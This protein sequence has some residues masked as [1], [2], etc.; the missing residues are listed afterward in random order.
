MIKLSVFY[1]GRAL[2]ELIDKHLHEKSRFGR[3]VSPFSNPHSNPHQKEKDSLLQCR[4]KAKSIAIGTHNFARGT[5]WTYPFKSYKLL[6]VSLENRSWH[7]FRE[8]GS[9]KFNSRLL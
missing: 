3:F 7:L 4:K 1:H 5:L 9:K 6:L 2:S 8:H